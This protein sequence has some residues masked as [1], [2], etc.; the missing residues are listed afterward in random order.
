MKI[1]HIIYNALFITFL[2][3]GKL[4]GQSAFI[5]NI[6]KS[7]GSLNEIVTING[8][9]F[10]N[11]PSDLRVYF[12]AAEATIVSSSENII[13]VR[14]PANATYDHINVINLSTGIRVASK[15][16][17]L[18]SFGGDNFE[19]S[20]ITSQSINP[21]GERG[22]FDLCVCDFNRDGNVDFVVANN[23]PQTGQLG[24]FSIYT[25]NSSIGNV[26]FGLSQQEI[27]KISFTDCGDL[28]GDGLQDLI[29]VEGGTQGFRIYVY[30]NTSS[31]STINF[32]LVNTLNLPRL[33][34]DNIR[35][36]GRVNIHD[37]DN[38]GRP[39]IIAT[40]KT[41]NFIDIFKNTS[42]SGN[43]SFDATPLQVLIEGSD[44]TS[45]IDI[46][47]LNND[48]FDDV[49]LITLRV[50]DIFILPNASDIGTIEFGNVIRLEQPGNLTSIKAADLNNDG[51]SDL[52]TIDGG[53][54]G[55][56]EVSNDAYIFLNNTDVN[57]GNIS[58]Q[59]NST[60]AVN[61]NPESLDFG[62]LNGDG[63][64]DIAI[65]SLKS[66]ATAG[67]SVL[68]NN[69]VGSTVTFESFQ[70]NTTSSSRS[71]RVVDVDADGR[72]DISF[73]HNVAGSSFGD[74]SVFLNKNCVEP[75]ITP[76]ERQVI[77]SNNDLVLQ[78]TQTNGAT[79]K[80]E[81]SIN[82]GTFNTIQES[83]VSFIN[84]QDFLNPGE[85]GNFRVTLSSEGGN[86]ENTSNTVNIIVNSDVINAPVPT[87]N[88]PVCPG[89]DL[90]LTSNV[91]GSTVFYEWTKP[92][93]T[94]ETVTDPVFTI[95]DF[96]PSDA[97]RYEL[98][99]QSGS[100]RSAAGTVLVGSRNLPFT[101][102]SADGGNLLC[103]G[104][105]KTLSVTSLDGF[106]YQ[107]RLN[108]TDLPGETNTSVD[109]SNPGTYTVMITDNT[110]CSEEVSPIE[111]QSVFQPDNNITADRNICVGLELDFQATAT[112]QAGLNISHRWDFGDGNT[113]TGEATSHIYTTAGNYLVTLT[114]FYD[115][116]EACEGIAQFPVSVRE[117]RDIPL[118]TPNPDGFN[119]CPSDSIRVELP[120]NFRSYAWSTGS[121][122]SFAFAKTERGQS[123]G[124]I[125][126]NW[127]DDAGCEG[128]S[129]EP[130]NNFPNSELVIESD[131][132][133]TDDT[134]RLTEG[135]QSVGLSVSFGSDLLWEPEEV[136]ENNTSNNV[137]VFPS[138][139]FTNIM[140]VGTTTNGC[141][142]TAN[143]VIVNNFLVPRRT[144]SPNGDGQGF[145]CWEILNASI[146]N[147]CTVYIFDS[148]GT[149]IQE[150]STPFDTNNCIWD[151]TT[152]GREAPEGVYYYALK[153]QD[154]NFNRSGS[155]LLAR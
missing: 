106:T 116:L 6:D 99:I 19:L 138:N 56:N 119:K 150:F 93:G 37:L 60:V 44:K 49:I 54:T 135:V 107:W 7:T 72:P 48:G 148:K 88:E 46:Q 105:N 39:E 111:I 30:E 137:T 126:V 26:N 16:K 144:F 55:S 69:S 112:G 122:E 131:L 25:N 102:I 117:V 120:D 89:D 152:E 121:T 104:D 81:L 96:Q 100:C 115:N 153:C 17:F 92:D 45:A 82:N 43:L 78:A 142:E 77:C 64:V 4:A 35:N 58:M 68:I 141:R 85:S 65:S 32:T 57:G 28:N 34:D 18:M 3:S 41:D 14:I 101:Q 123:G 79:Y 132:T 5:S 11:D 86:C 40:N 134:I 97:G 20:N 62:D 109:I 33:P 38:D 130:Y 22:V 143:V 15:E 76:D 63:L 12:G 1:K 24:R 47:D 155:I 83:D 154:A 50:S 91:T 103:I 127:T 129:E 66:N 13:E 84:S 61:G 36:I 42:S 59:R 125:S 23:N 67:L 90:I 145:E 75:I 133:I 136:I 8:R 2:A 128:F 73:T 74:L 21:T 124:S 53:V 71:I 80:W 51:F 94:T 146:L 9:G 27:D 118:T 87:S 113:G 149:I 139:A 108:G 114:S 147:G 52:V 151:G 95:S 29:L 31:G 70:L 140:A 98:V 10:S 110:G